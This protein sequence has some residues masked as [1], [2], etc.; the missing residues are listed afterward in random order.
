MYEKSCK[1]IDSKEAERY[2]DDIVGT[3]EYLSKE[4]ERLDEENKKLKSEHYKN[5]E[6]SKLSKENKELKEQLYAAEI[7]N[8]FV[9]TEDEEKRISDWQNKH[10]ERKHPTK[11]FGAAG[12]ELTYLFT[13]TGIGTF[14]TVK[15]VCGEKYEFRKP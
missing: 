14:G 2:A 10:N 11:Y 15:C 4:I 13:P 6:I 8:E 3:I 9:L 12:G 1:I 5:E 7:R